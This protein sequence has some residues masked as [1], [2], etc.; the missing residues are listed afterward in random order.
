MQKRDSAY[1]GLI[2]N[3]SHILEEGRKQAYSAVNAILVRTYWEIGKQI[4]VFEQKGNA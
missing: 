2:I 3:I 4:V 1:G